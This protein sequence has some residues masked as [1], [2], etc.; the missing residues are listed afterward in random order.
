ME[1]KS[2]NEK[3][4]WLSQSEYRNIVMFL[5]SLPIPLY[6]ERMAPGVIVHDTKGNRVWLKS[7]RELRAFKTILNRV[8]SA[9]LDTN[10][11]DKNAKSYNTPYKY[12]TIT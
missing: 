6:V 3:G 11:Q 9:Y 2:N 8:L 12:V 10:G 1:R 4:F 5:K 7:K